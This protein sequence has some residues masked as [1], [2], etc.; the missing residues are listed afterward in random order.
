MEIEQELE[1]TREISALDTSIQPHSYLKTHH[2][3]RSKEVY[4]V[5]LDDLEAIRADNRRGDRQWSVGLSIFSGF[6]FLLVGT[7][8]QMGFALPF[9]ALGMCVVGLAA[10]AILMVE[11]LQGR[12]SAQN[13]IDQI[14]RE[15]N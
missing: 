1:E 8:L 10:G 5:F 14:I 9:G 13:R 7:W 2:R 12:K 11:G 6:F 3:T 15:S 4:S